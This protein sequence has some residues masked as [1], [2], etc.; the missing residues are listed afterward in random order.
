MPG[1]YGS[2]LGVL[3][4]I[5]LISLSF[6]LKVII[7]GIMFFFGTLATEEIEK[8]SAVEDNPI[9]V[10]DEIAGMWVTLMI[11][12]AG[13]WWIAA[14][15]LLFRVMDVSKPFPIRKLESVKR[16]YGVMLDDILAGVYAGVILVAVERFIL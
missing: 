8:E 16:G 7:L 9:I 1:T 11:A 3:L 5:S 2:I 12:P 4:F 10:I 14:S 13:I 15:L 6:Q